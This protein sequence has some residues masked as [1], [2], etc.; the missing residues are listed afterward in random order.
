MSATAFQRKRRELVKQA[1]EK[2]Q[3]EEKKK[4]EKKVDKNSKGGK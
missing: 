1:L 4:E 3:Q 2:K